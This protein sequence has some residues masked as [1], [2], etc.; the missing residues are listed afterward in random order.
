MKA[1]KNFL[2]ALS[3]AIV[4]WVGASWGNIVAHNTND[5]QYWKYN[6]FILLAELR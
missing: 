5:C 2:F 1:V 3:I 4:L 6:A